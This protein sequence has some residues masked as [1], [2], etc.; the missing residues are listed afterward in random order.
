MPSIYTAGGNNE[1]YSATNIDFTEITIH[2]LNIITIRNSDQAF[3][4]FTVK[5]TKLLFS[6]FIS[7]QE[8]DEGD[9]RLQKQGED[10][11]TK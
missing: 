11:Y 7:F 4:I 10:T 8:M 3:Y 9:C 1:K 6:G 2:C 5:K